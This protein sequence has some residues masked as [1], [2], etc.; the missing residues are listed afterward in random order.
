MQRLTPAHVTPA[1]RALFDPR[2]P[3]APRCFAMLD[4]IAH[5]G[6]IL[7][8]S[9]SDPTWAVVQ[10]AYDGSLFLG[11]R[12]TAPVLAEVFDLLR[13]EGEVV[14]GLRLDDP[15]QRLLPPRPDYDERALEFHDR[16]LGEGLAQYLHMLPDGCEIRRLDRELVM[17]TEWGP[18]DVRFVGGIEAWEKTC[19]GYCLMHEDEIRCEATAFSIVFGAGT[20]PSHSAQSSASIAPRS[21]GSVST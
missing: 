7:C 12:I 18:N 20:G 14:V 13:S 6:T 2:E 21:A 9:S 11:G 17:R 4:G 15:R 19:L 16:P 8:D 3:Q 5:S 10:E 1:L